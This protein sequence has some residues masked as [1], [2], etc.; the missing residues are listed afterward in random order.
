MR[1]NVGKAE[2]VGDKL[3]ALAKFLHTRRHAGEWNQDTKVVKIHQS[4]INFDQMKIKYKSIRWLSYHTFLIRTQAGEL[5]SIYLCI[6]TCSRPFLFQEGKFWKFLLKDIALR[7]WKF[8]FWVLIRKFLFAAI[9]TLT[10]GSVNAFANI[11]LQTADVS[12]FFFLR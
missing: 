6:S 1:E 10:F 11:I 7:T 8:C 3:K 4:E 12:V 5:S 9:M 2:G